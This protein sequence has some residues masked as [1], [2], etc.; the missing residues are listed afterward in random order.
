MWISFPKPEDL[1]WCQVDTLDEGIEGDVFYLCLRL[2]KNGEPF[3][4]CKFRTLPRW[5][6]DSHDVVYAQWKPKYDPR[7]N[8]LGNL[9][10]KFGIDELPQIVV[11]V[12]RDKVMNMIGP[13]PISRS[14]T[15]KAG[16]TDYEISH[17]LQVK[18]WLIGWLTIRRYLR[19]M[20][21]IPEGVDDDLYARAFL[22]YLL[23]HLDP[24]LIPT[25]KV[26]LI[27]GDSILLPFD[28]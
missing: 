22:S 27:L 16:V 4:E 11:N 24:K 25:F 10:R 20:D 2:G 5:S 21:A 26:M 1:H 17:I 8:I 9:V 19:T 18:P 3:Y 14:D 23:Q 28:H 15:T 6:Q 12:C 7:A 13:R